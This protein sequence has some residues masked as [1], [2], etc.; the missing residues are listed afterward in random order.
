MLEHLDWL[1]S[2]FTLSTAPA[3]RG[4]LSQSRTRSRQRCAS[5]GL[6]CSSILDDIRRA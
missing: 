2:Q 6:Q 5:T 4:A 1:L 3:R